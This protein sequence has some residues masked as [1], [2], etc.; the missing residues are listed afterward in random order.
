MYGNPGPKSALVAT[1]ALALVGLGIAVRTIVFCRGYS[2]ILD[3]CS[4]SLDIFFGG[5]RS[6]LHTLPRNQAAPLGYLVV[7]KCILPLFGMNDYTTRLFP[8]FL[9]IIAIPGAVLLASFVFNSLRTPAAFLVAVG[10]VSFN[11]GA[12][13]YS[14]TAKQYSVESAVTIFLLLAFAAYL[15]TAK[16]ARQQKTRSIMLALSPILVWFSFG[17]VFVVAA[18]FSVLFLRALF[19]R[20]RQALAIAAAFG[21]NALTQLTLF[22]FL[23][24][25]SVSVN[26]RMVRAWTAAYMPL[27]PPAR[28][29]AWLYN[30]FCS[31]GEMTIHLR[32]SPLVTLSIILVTWTA[33]RRRSWFALVLV[34]SVLLCLAA[35]AARVYPFAGRLLLFLM[36]C[37][38]FMVALALEFVELRNPGVAG[39]LGS[40][41]VIAAGFAALRYGVIRYRGVDDVRGVYEEMIAGMHSGDQLWVAPLA[42]PCFQYYSLWM[43]PPPGVDVHLPQNGDLPRLPDGRDWILVM[44]TPWAPGEGESWLREAESGGR[45][46]ES[47]DRQWTTAR[48]FEKR[49][50]DDGS[51]VGDELTTPTLFQRWVGENVKSSQGEKHEQAEHGGGGSRTNRRR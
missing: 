33:I 7:Q 28:T 2:L 31:V 12:I 29:V 20:R 25:R 36:P 4:I 1:T 21:I 26:R 11:R 10:L 43:P 27:W 39:I 34:I 37:F 46:I 8:F 18:I 42:G 24:M 9:G 5:I 30:S 23:S 50:D 40:V 16:S 45:P 47:F 41:V 35:S 44:R 19:L 51:G 13:S 6:F 48:L 17:A 32:L 15:A 22:Y 3:E 14:A 49:P 38:V